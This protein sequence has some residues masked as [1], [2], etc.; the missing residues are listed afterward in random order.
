MCIAALLTITKTW[1]QLRCPSKDEG[2]NKLWYIHTVQ[3][4]SV[5]KINELSSYEKIQET[6]YKCILVS[7][8]S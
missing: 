5:I 1:T 8:R 6:R 3:C 7:E 4:F 2:V